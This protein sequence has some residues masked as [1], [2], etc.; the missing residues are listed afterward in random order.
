M[1]TPALDTLYAAAFT[2]GTAPAIDATLTMRP[3]R[4][5]IMC[6]AAAWAQYTVPSRLTSMMRSQSSSEIAITGP[7]LVR[8]ARRM[9][10]AFTSTS[11]RPQL[12]AM[13]STARAAC[14]GSETSRSTSRTCPPSALM[15]SATAA[16][17]SALRSQS[18]TRSPRRARAS[19]VARPMPDAAP[20]TAA[21]FSDI[22]RFSF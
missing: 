10:A 16:S 14:A 3:A 7:W 13:P 2:R 5:C 9:P 12:S 21:T 17:P 19:A 11:R 1:R 22:S 15:V 8:P 4:R 20:V 18:A 6:F